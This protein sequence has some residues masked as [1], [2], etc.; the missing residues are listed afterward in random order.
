MED[1][2]NGMDPLET[3]YAR[4]LDPFCHHEAASFHPAP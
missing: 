4:A 2:M 3:D 1:Q